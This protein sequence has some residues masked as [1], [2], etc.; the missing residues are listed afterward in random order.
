MIDIQG[1]KKKIKIKNSGRSLSIPQ[2]AL[3]KN[4]HFNKFDGS[5]FHQIRIVRFFKFFIGHASCIAARQ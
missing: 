5:I 2:L 4:L 1:K 3:D